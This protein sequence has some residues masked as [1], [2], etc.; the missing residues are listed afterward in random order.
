MYK[1]VDH[2]QKRSMH[3]LSCLKVFQISKVQAHSH[4]ITNELYTEFKLPK[5]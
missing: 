2:I 5:Y 3:E 4:E 1:D